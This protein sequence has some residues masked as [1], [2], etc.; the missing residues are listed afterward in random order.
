MLHVKLNISVLELKRLISQYL[1]PSARCSHSE[2]QWQTKKK[3]K[4]PCMVLTSCNR[5]AIYILYFDL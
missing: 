4:P 5:I 2:K 3:R 1:N